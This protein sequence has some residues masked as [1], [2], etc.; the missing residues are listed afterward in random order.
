MLIHPSIVISLLLVIRLAAPSRPTTLAPYFAKKAIDSTKANDLLKSKCQRR[1]SKGVL[2]T[3]ALKKSLE[4]GEN[5]KVGAVI[6][7]LDGE[8][9]STVLDATLYLPAPIT[10]SKT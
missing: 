9:I 4:K 3:T 2:T 1:W 8:E 6:E 10:C 5:T 7:G